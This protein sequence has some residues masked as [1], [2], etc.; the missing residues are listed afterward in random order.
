MKPPLPGLS[1]KIVRGRPLLPT[2]IVNLLAGCPVSEAN[3]D[4]CPLHA[5]RNLP[6][7]EALDW[8]AGLST[9]DKAF[10]LQY[11]HC[12]LA[13]SIEVERA[14]REKR[15]TRHSSMARKTPQHS[16]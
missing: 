8:V 4:H 3:P 15:A 12:C 9:D 13:Y 5:V 14:A 6:L 10:L 11:H 7:D 16:A 2:A 1:G